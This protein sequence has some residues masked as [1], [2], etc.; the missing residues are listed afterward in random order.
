MGGGSSKPISNVDPVTTA[1]QMQTSCNGNPLPIM[2]GKSRVTGNI[3]WY[4]AFT[5]VPHV[6]NTGGD[7]GGKGG[8]GG[9]GRGS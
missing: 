4:G 2:Y 6:Q 8:G 3:L 9:G 5:P 7:G 1:I